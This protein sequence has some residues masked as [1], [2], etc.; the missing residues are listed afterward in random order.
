MKINSLIIILI[1]LS[2]VACNK[3]EEEKKE[4]T[5]SISGK[6]ALYDEGQTSIR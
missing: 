1:T 5:S 4:T 3:D 6:V 2:F